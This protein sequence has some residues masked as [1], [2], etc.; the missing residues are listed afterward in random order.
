MKHHK[1]NIYFYMSPFRLSVK[2]F[3]TAVLKVASLLAISSC[4][5]KIIEISS[6]Y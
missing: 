5:S 3:V 1:V 2:Q 6:E 4:P